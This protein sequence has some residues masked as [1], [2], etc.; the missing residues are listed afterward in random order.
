M[1][2]VFA[3]MYLYAVGFGLVVFLNLFF[4]PFFLSLPPVSLSLVLINW[5]KWSTIPACPSQLYALF[6]LFLF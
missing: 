6:F 2:L 5:T 4:G 1:A 3:A